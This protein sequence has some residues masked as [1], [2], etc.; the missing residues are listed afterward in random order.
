MINTELKLKVLRSARDLVQAGWT[1]HFYA[2]DKDGKSLDWEPISMKD[3]RFNAC[4]VCTTGAVLFAGLDNGFSGEAGLGVL[5]KLVRPILDE[6]AVT[7][8]IPT[9]EIANWNDRMGVTQSDSLRALDN[10]IKRLEKG[11]ASAE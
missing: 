7:I 6:V 2:R 4:Q 1:K 5:E 3:K 9:V 11:E 8:G 10:T